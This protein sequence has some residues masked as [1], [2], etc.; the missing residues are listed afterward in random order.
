MD[1]SRIKVLENSKRNSLLKRIN[2]LEDEVSELKKHR[3]TLKENEARYS[4]FVEHFQGIA[5]QAIVENIDTFKPSFFYGEVESI[6]GYSQ[7][8]FIEKKVTWDELIHRDDLLMVIKEGEKLVST[9]GYVADNE[10]RIH[11]KDGSIRWV[12][13]VCSQSPAENIFQGTIRDVT[14]RKRAEE[15]LRESERRYRSLIDAAPVPIIVCTNDGTI[16]YLNQAFVKTF[17]WE[18]KE[19]A[20][21]PVGSSAYGLLSEAREMLT[22][23]IER[24]V[25]EGPFETKCF[26]RSGLVLD[27]QMTVSSFFDNKGRPAG[28][29][30]VLRD[31]TKIKKLEAQVRHTQKMEA[32]GTLAGGIAHDFNNILAAIIGYSELTLDYA[33]RGTQIEANLKEV[34]RAGRR[35]RELVKQILAFSR[36]TEKEKKPVQIA[37]VIKEALKLLRSS[38]PS[39]IQIQSH[40]EKDLGLVNADPTQVHQVLMN[41]CTNAGYAMR[42]KGGTLT[43]NLVKEMI[44]K[45]FVDIH[46]GISPG[47]H[48][49]L[50]VRDT[51]EGIPPDIM[52]SIFTPY[53]TTKTAEEGTGMGLSVVHGIVKSY[54]GEIT[55]ESETGKGSE[56]TVYFPSIIAEVDT[57]VTWEC[58]TPRGCEHILFVDDE[59][60]LTDIAKSGLSSLG[61]N[62]SVETSSLKALALF[63]NE[64]EAFD[65]VITDMTMPYMNGDELSRK[66]LA[67]RKDIPIM[68][69]T[70]YNTMITK[71]ISEEIGIRA[72]LMKPIEIKDL[73]RKIREVLDRT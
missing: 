40:I 63:Q 16:D 46:P 59:A 30:I 21:K 70:G 12:N 60:S 54:G 32:I 44:G 35:A 41:L 3:D 42:K 19:L 57:I 22:E 68:M 56:F 10:Y 8:D 18:E 47:P 25:F 7:E 73:A 31:V 55:V 34:L 2:E 28:N 58:P 14:I 72:F 39:T 13:D 4:L 45:R 62:I 23:M 38:I 9:S 64:P 71:E 43:V 6:T 65:L 17:E 29:I 61:Y 24:Q 26:T 33:P 15:A 66:I 52:E 27:I 37:P 36:E 1:N 49:R 50:T 53:F 69:V 51:G 67:I 48:L 20:G 5:Y 11:Q